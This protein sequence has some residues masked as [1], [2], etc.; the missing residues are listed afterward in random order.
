M[1]K[2]GKYIIKP[3]FNLSKG[4]KGDKGDPGED[5]SFS[6]P[7]STDDV[8]YR[9]NIL[10]D[11]IDQLLYLV[12]V[13]ETF[14]SSNILFEKGQ[15]LTSIFL[16]WTY[17]KSVESQSI[18]GIN[19]ISPSLLI[20][21]RNKNVTLSN[22]SI[23]TTIILTTD[24]ETSDDNDP[25][26][27]TLNLKFAN[28]IYYGKSI[29][30]TLN[31]AFV[32]ALPSNSLQLD[33]FKSFTIN[34]GVSEYGYFAS[35]VAYG[36]P[37]FLAGGFVGGIQLEAIISFTNASG[38]TEDYYIHRTVNDSLGLTTIQAI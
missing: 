1:S 29:T 3:D 32:L 8:D 30:G 18:T 14:T 35:P 37:S 21:D 22:V 16:T 10:T 27:K 7:L 36:L 31:S 2:C 25:K 20:T 5:G 23:D 34:A 38:Y 28:K 6:L 11:I 19:V 24:D 17:N 4:D 13:I 15:V 9:G 33:R 12:L 26:V